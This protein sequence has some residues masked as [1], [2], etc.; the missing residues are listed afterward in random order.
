MSCLQDIKKKSDWHA[1]CENYFVIVCDDWMMS[2]S[3]KERAHIKVYVVQSN[4]LCPH[5]E[6]LDG[7]IIY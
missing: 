2:W 1:L 3:M 6:T 5:W 4:D 7:Y